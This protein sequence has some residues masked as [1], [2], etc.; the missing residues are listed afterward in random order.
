VTLSGELPTKEFLSRTGG[1]GLVRSEYLVRAAGSSWCAEP[2]RRAVT[3]YLRE[4]HT[5]LDARPLWYRFCDLEARDTAVLA[6]AHTAR[7][8]EDNPIIGCRALRRA[9]HPGSDLDHELDALAAIA[10][11]LPGLGLMAPFVQDE[12]EVGTWI[13]TLRR[14]GFHGPFGAMIEIPS[15]LSRLEQIIDTGVSYLVVGLNDLTGLLLGAGRGTGRYDYR[16]PAVTDAVRHV[17][18]T[19]AR[20]RVTVRIAGNFGAELP[21]HFPELPVSAF[22]LHYQDWA[23]FRPE[24]EALARPDR[25]LAARLRRAS[26]QRLVAAGLLEAGNAIRVAGMRATTIG[27]IA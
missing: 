6:D 11:D 7:P 23:E 9:S 20:R 3:E 8:R 14:R 5:R 10:A 4:L 13:G 25:D 17:L 12:H 22:S 21:A 27:R 19:G 2:A 24:D 26:D 15:A 1:V 16:H 18:D